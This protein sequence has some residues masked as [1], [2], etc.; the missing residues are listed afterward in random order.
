MLDIIVR[1]GKSDKMFNQPLM[2]TILLV[3]DDKLLVEALA[4]AIK[5]IEDGGLQLNILPAYNGADA[6]PILANKSIDL[7]LSGL[8][9]PKM[10][11]FEL[12]NHVKQTQPDL[13]IIVVSGGGITL[14]T[15]P[16]LKENV[17][18]YFRKPIQ[19]IEG[20]R[21]TLYEGLKIEGSYSG[22]LKAKEN[23]VAGTKDEYLSKQPRCSKEIIIVSPIYAA[24]NHY[25]CEIV[26]EAKDLLPWAKNHAKGVSSSDQKEQAARE[27]LPLW[28]GTADS[29]E[30]RASY[31][32][33][34]MYK[35]LRPYVSDFVEDGIAKIYCSECQSLVTDLQMDRKDERS[36]GRWSYWTDVWKCPHGHQ[37][38][39]E[40]HEL[41]FYM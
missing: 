35:V 29:S 40:E 24:E 32:P 39:Y 17:D 22:K 28:L 7:L 8:I 26:V 18:T 4:I 36:S 33:H 9:M 38:Y 20:F 12:I 1:K 10:D 16:F 31:A 19:D 13:P 5:A 23:N 25:T 6:L 41:H 21:N 3:D 15:E 14:E 37:L 30:A 11:G 2:K 34:F 27:A